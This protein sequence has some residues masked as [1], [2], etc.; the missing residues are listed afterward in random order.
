[1][2]IGKATMENSMEIPKKKILI[3]LLYGPIIPLLGICVL[4][5]AVLSAQSCPTL[6]DSVDCNPPGSSVYGDSPGKN[7]RVGC[8]LGIYPPPKKRKH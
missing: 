6:C 3:E 1:M 7:T 8:H 4:C 5:C 2:N